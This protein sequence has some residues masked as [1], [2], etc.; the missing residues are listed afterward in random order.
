MDLFAGQRELFDRFRH[1][2]PSLDNIWGSPGI[3]ESLPLIFKDHVTTQ[4]AKSQKY[5]IQSLARLQ[6]LVQIKDIPVR[7]ISPTEKNAM[8]QYCQ[9]ILYLV[10]EQRKM[11]GEFAY[12][13]EQLK[14]VR[15]LLTDLIGDTADSQVIVQEG[16]HPLPLQ[17]ET[18]DM[19]QAQCALFTR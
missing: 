19:Y 7:D 17:K 4:W 3:L 9:H 10:H 16:Q 6:K 11:I 8:A 14:D 1:P 12:Q 5:Y 2:M 13:S 18:R 15:A